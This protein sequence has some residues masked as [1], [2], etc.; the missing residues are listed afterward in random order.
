MTLIQDFLSLLGGCFSFYFANNRGGFG[1]ALFV[2]V[3]LAALC[4]WACSSYSRLWN[5]RY[6]VTL[7]HH[8]LCAL[9]AIL[10]LCSVAMSHAMA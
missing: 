1:L 7:T 3:E 2:G 6:R 10:T 9:A 8:V 5:L 4:W